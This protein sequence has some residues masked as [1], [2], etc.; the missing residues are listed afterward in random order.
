MLY[1]TTRHKQQLSDTPAQAEVGA[2]LMVKR[3]LKLFM[4]YYKFQSQFKSNFD[5]TKMSLNDYNDFRTKLIT[6]HLTQLPVRQSNGV[7]KN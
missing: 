5:W 7:M 6:I 4:A 2:R 1:N 3:K